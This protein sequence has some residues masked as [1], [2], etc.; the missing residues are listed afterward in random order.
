M[1]SKEFAIAIS[2][3]LARLLFQPTRLTRLFLF[4]SSSWH[5]AH[6]VKSAL[7]VES[8]TKRPT[9]G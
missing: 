4:R 7:E 5:I 1:S 3:A 8:I 9:Q 6:A 2:P